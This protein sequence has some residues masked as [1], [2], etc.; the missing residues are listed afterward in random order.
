[1][2][3][4]YSVPIGTIAGAVIASQAEDDIERLEKKIKDTQAALAADEAKLFAAKTLQADITSM[5]V[6]RSNPSH[7]PL[8]TERPKKTD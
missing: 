6:S 4:E 7:G 5:R 2:P 8:L 1:M 3:Y